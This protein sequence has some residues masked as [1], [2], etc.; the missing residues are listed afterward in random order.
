MIRVNSGDVEIK[1]DFGSFIFKPTMGNCINIGSPSDVISVFGDLHLIGA[2]LDFISQKSYFRTQTKKV[3]RAALL[4]LNAC[5]KEDITK[6]IG[7]EAPSKNRVNYVKGAMPVNDVITI[8]RH[9]MKHMII[10]KPSDTE[11]KKGEFS[12]E[13]DASEIVDMAMLHLGLSE[14]EALNLSM[15]RFQSMI[16]IKFPEKKSSFPTD[17]EYDE[18]MEWANKVNEARS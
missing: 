5:C 4:V 13:F 1:S 7:Y 18:T 9:L 11:K 8:A 3:L 10:G 2:N 15:T 17:Q 6:L 12:K 16:A 14:S